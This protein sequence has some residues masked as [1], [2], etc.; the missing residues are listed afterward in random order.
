MAN[1]PF[2][3][4]DSAHE[5]LRLLAL[6][7]AEAAEEI[8]RDVAA[9]ADRAN[10]RHLDAL[11]LVAFKLKQLEIHVTGSRGI[12]ND[13]RM[14]RRVLVGDGVPVRQISRQN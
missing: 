2:D 11:R 4:L 5:Y 12:V 3:N 1:T 8:D 9:G 14:L 13:L 7:V 6:Q 10:T